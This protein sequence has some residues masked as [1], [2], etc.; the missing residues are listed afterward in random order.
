MSEIKS[1][2]N[3][4][5]HQLESLLAS[6]LDVIF[7]IS[8]TGKLNYISQSSF[9][10]LGY[11]PE[12]IIE[13][14]ISDFILPENLNDYFKEMSILFRENNV[15]TFRAD[16]QHKNGS[17]IPVEITGTVVEIDGKLMGQ[18][19][20]RDIRQ[21][22][23]TQQKL[24]SSENIFKA[25]WENSK[26]G[27]RLTDEDGIIVLCNNAFAQ[28]FGKNIDE[29][30]NR[31]ISDL[32][33]EEKQEFVIG[34]YKQN[35]IQGMV[36]DYLESSAVL[37]NGEK[38][39]FEI[40]NSIIEDP[41]EKRFLLSIFR[42]ISERK[43]SEELLE[44]KGRLLQGIAKATNALITDSAYIDGFNLTLEIL[45]EAAGADRVY[46]YQH[47]EDDETGELYFTPLFEWTAEGVHSQLEDNLLGKLSYSRF[48]SLKF[49]EAFSNGETLKFIIKNLPKEYQEIFIDNNIK[50]IILV[51]ILIEGAYWGFIGFDEC[52]SDRMWS[53]D[54]ESILSAMAAT[55]G[56][57][58]KKNKFREELIRKNVELD[59]AVKE[60]EK[61]AKARSEF[62][63]LMSHEIRTPMNGVIGMTGLLLETMLSESQKDYVNTIRLS[64]EQLLVI[65]ND[66]L[67]F[68]KI[69]SEKLEL[70]T[71]PFDLR[72]CIED[73]M[74]LI[75][76]KVAEQD[77]ELF[78]N[79]DENTP[80]AIRGDVTR[81]RQILTNLL[82]NAVKFTH[83]GEVEISV[84]SEHIDF[85][86]YIFKF[87]VRDTGMGI[88][89]DKLDKLFKPFSQV[90][91]STTRN[92]GG[93]GLGLVISKRIVELMG[94]EIGLTSVEG[95]GSNFYFTIK[96][97][98]VTSD[99]KVYLFESAPELLGKRVLIIDLNKSN[100]MML[101]TLAKRWRM[102]S[103]LITDLSNVKPKLELYPDFDLFIINTS[104]LNGKVYSLVDK[105][106]S[107]VPKKNIG[108]ILIKAH[109]KDL[110]VIESDR[111][112]FC[113]VLSK[114][115]RRKQLHQTILSFIQ[116]GLNSSQSNLVEKEVQHIFSTDKIRILLAEDNNVNQMV[117]SRML[118]RIG[119]N[120]DI[121]SNGKEAVDAVE[122]IE[123]DLVFMDISM[124]EM[125]GLTACS[126]IKSSTTIKKIPIIIAMTANAMS[127]DKENYLKVGMDD[128][129]S[130]PVNL[131]E[132]RKIIIKWTDKIV[133]EKHIETR[134]AID[135]EIELRFI[136]EKK[137]SFLQDLKTDSDLEFFK[138]MLDI[139]IRE[140]PKNIEAIRNSIFQNNADHL[141]FYVH[142]LKGS[143]LT[144]GIECVLDNF[145]I[146]EDMALDNNINEESLRIFK[147]VSEQFESILEEIVLLKNKYSG[148][149]FS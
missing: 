83:K 96:A 76:T 88:P 33:F 41:S 55:I 138:E 37:W 45:G 135:S 107:L 72:E 48:A 39:F 44:K 49:Y 136:E 28:L 108:F 26:D 62:L 60:A 77:I 82:S 35:F 10:L 124:P 147:K 74:D 101:N 70:E 14:S 110:D 90:D 102:S 122:S 86:D 137:I 78:Y 51:P 129:I 63:A 117:A 34:K 29:L 8:P 116:I 115:V 132:L 65:I 104:S 106:K 15:I 52:H 20:I 7:R 16:L 131:E 1:D 56:E 130:K 111:N 73:S 113:R 97:E 100:G 42:D 149:K 36:K 6:S 94:G 134:K 5:V 54:E 146:L 75:S 47:K 58:L 21:R 61:A 148:I 99:K 144:L 67:D 59:V 85:K 84:S 133:H 46:I 127:G 2:Q 17:K 79:I 81:L 145:K 12:E 31:P 95:K 53:N 93:T 91:S 143:C 114:P 32:Y 50:S 19:T 27:M 22:I 64:G 125:D 71:Q 89:K 9:N 18:G 139:Y 38:L 120:A 43:V 57:V 11:N 141:R 109:G 66:I 23:E 4:K 121:V 68:S 40:S 92:F 103:D 13:K 80:Y 30:I 123:Y 128:Y 118:Q 119:F 3:S 105:I 112:P 140:I 98:S 24:V 126:I 69:E 25:I 142:K 87:N